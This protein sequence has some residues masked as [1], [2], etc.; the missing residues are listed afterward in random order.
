MDDRS[1]KGFFLYVGVGMGTF[2]LA[3]YILRGLGLLSFLPGLFLMVPFLL[4][5]FS[6]L[7]WGI[8]KTRI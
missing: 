7:L 6:L 8:G 5:F 1:G 3:S 2:F 4:A